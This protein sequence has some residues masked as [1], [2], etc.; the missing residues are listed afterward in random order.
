MAWTL[1]RQSSSHQDWTGDAV[2]AN[3]TNSSST[4][5]I[6][7]FAQFDIQV[8]HATHDDSSTYALDWSN[9]GGTTWERVT[10]VNTSGVSG[11]SSTSVT[12]MPG[13]LFRLT[14]TATDANAGATLTPHVT[15]KRR[16]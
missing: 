3:A 11:S 10:T 7:P 2:A 15:L 4:L 16:G 1:D 8:L 5:P 12:G 14:V 9:D 13:A 6:G